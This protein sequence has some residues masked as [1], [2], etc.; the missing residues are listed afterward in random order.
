MGEILTQQE[1]DQLLRSLDDGTS[2]VIPDAPSTGNKIRSYDFR[3]ANRIPR[4]QMKTLHSIYENFAR[5]FSTYLTGT[6]GVLCDA[7]IVSIEEQTFQEFT[8]STPPAS[9]LAILKMEPLHGPTL[10]QLSPEIAYAILE[11]LLGGSGSP[12]ENRRM[13]TEIDLVILEKIVRQLLPII[14]GAWDKIVKV[15]T[16][17]DGME[18]SLQFAQIVQ[19]SETIVIIT[20]NAK[21]GTVEALLNFCLPQIALEPVAKD[22]NTRLL[23]VGRIDRKNT[24]NYHDSIL[25]MIRTTPVNL[26]AILSETT[27]TVSELMNLQVGDVIQ[28]DSKLG[29]NMVLKIG[30]IPRLEGVLGSRGNRYAVRITGINYEEEA[31][32]E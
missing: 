23:A 14:S 26:K 27:I 9:L 19:P 5:V 17:L 15:E 32:Y 13:F 1:I 12:A 20:I 2:S 8:N 31:D 21:I 24:E 16:V 22:L 4:D 25:E 30:H 6:L 18:T 3:T 29:D 28:L 7:D 11:C 10:F